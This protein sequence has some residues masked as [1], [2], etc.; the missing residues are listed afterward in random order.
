MSN[1]FLFSVTAAD[2][3]IQTFCTG[4]KGGQNQNRKEKG[5]RLIHRAS[6]ARG[7]GREFREQIQNKRAAFLRLIETPEFK[8]WHRKEVSR[9]IHMH[10]EPIQD[11]VDRQMDANNLRVEI[12]TEIGW[13]EITEP[14]KTLPFKGATV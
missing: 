10:F 3:E 6:G 13:R 14:G 2:F 9:R 8:A 4:G 12:L 11:V 5:V 1:R 7:E